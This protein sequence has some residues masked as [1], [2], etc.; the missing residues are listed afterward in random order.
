MKKVVIGVEE[1]IRVY[2][3]C[4]MV[5]VSF[6]VFAGALC[7]NKTTWKKKKKWGSKKMLKKEEFI[8]L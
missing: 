2:V 7:G 6:R 1:D 4:Y 3:V 8:V 5:M